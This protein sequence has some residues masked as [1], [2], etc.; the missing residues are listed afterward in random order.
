MRRATVDIRVVGLFDLHEVDRGHIAAEAARSL[1]IAD[2]EVDLEELRLCLPSRMIR[3][4]GLA[5]LHTR[6]GSYEGV[7]REEVVYDAV[8]LTILG[9]FCT[10]DVLE[11]PDDR[12][13]TVGRLPLLQLDLVVDE[14]RRTL[15]VNPA[16]G[17]VPTLECYSAGG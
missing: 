10:T 16:H 3:H 15:V 9:D 13:P 8:R 14:D 5:H 4:L 6:R 1:A 11:I 12:P 17:G 2:V 7:L